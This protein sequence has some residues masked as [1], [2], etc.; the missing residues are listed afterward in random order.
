MNARRPYTWKAEKYK[1]PSNG[2]HWQI[3]LAESGSFSP[4]ICRI[5]DGPNDS[6]YARLI[7]TAPELLKALVDLLG[8]PLSDKDHNGHCQ[9]CGREFEPHQ[10]LCQS[11]DCPGFQARAVITKATSK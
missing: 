8:E 11:D 2:G 1:N 3:E 6:A 7:A 10:E 4:A 5:Y 9:H